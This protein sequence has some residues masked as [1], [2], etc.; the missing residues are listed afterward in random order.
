MRGVFFSAVFL[1]PMVLGRAERY[2]IRQGTEGVV[3]TMRQTGRALG[4]ALVA[5][6]VLGASWW[7]GPFGSRTVRGFDGGFYWLWSVAWGAFAL[8]GLLGARYH[9]RWTITDREIIRRDPFSPSPQRFSRG[10]T[11]VLQQHIFDWSGRTRP[12]FPYRLRLVGADGR[13]TAAE[14]LFSTAEGMA[15]FVKALRL[16][17]AVTVQESP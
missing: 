17:V 14:F 6:A 3:V 12:V 4:V 11:V 15:Q 2:T 5:A 1:P 13:A 10:D 9:E 8:L 7:L 16:V